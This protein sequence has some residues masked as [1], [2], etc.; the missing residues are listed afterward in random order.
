MLWEEY[1]K[2]YGYPVS[3]WLSNDHQREFLLVSMICNMLGWD[4]SN[5]LSLDKNPNNFIYRILDSNNF[6]N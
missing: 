3:K 5:F 2:Y 1:E 4:L 6:K